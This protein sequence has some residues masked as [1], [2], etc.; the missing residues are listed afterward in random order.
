M[1]ISDGAVRLFNN[2]PWI[3]SKDDQTWYESNLP[4]RQSAPQA[5]EAEIRHFNHHQSKFQNPQKAKQNSADQITI[6]ALQAKLMDQ[7]KL[8]E[9]LY[10]DRNALYRDPG[11]GGTYRRQSTVDMAKSDL[12]ESTASFSFDASEDMQ[13]VWSR[14]ARMKFRISG[15]VS[16]VPG[17]LFHYLPQTVV[18]DNWWHLCAQVGLTEQLARLFYYHPENGQESAVAKAKPVQRGPIISCQGD[19]ID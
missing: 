13:V 6:E 4:R 15:Q 11:V 18:A 8:T 2:T 16:R 17:H 9:Q 12:L 1:N 7:Q 14:N 10:D 5:T 3:W 19:Y